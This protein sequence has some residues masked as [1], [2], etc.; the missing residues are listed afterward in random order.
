MTPVWTHKGLAFGLV[1]VRMD[2]RSELEPAVEVRHP[3][4]EPLMDIC[5]GM[6]ALM[7][8]IR[9]AFDPFYEPTYPFTITGELS[10]D[11]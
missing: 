7:I 5:E 6:Y 9:L 1:P 11:Q 4:F 8:T 10:S 3:I 2:M